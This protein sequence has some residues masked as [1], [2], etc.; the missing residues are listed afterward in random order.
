LNAFLPLV[1]HALLESF[2]LLTRACSAFARFCVAGIEADEAR[3]R[4]SVETAT[5][6]ATAL[7][8]HLGYARA[9]ELVAR[10]RAT[11]RGLRETAVADGFISP[12]DF[13]AATSAEAVC[14]LGFTSPKEP[15]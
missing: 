3:C 2:D 8:P 11:G 7:V 1:S 6:T 13:D 12:D 15:Q 4:Q 10:A 5:A 14:R 9:S